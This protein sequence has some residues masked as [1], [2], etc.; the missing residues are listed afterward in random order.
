MGVA[1]ALIAND[2]VERLRERIAEGGLQPGDMMEY[3]DL[4]REWDVSMHVAF[5]ALRLLRDE[6]LTGKVRGAHGMMVTEE[7]AGI[8]QAWRPPPPPALEFRAKVVRIAVALADA[9]G[10]GAVSMRRIA[11]RLGTATM[12][13]YR[14]VRPRARLDMLMADAVFA[15]HRPPRRPRGDWRAQLEQVCRL[16]WEMYRRRPW[17]ARIVRFEPSDLGEFEQPGLGEHVHAHTEWAMRALAGRGE[18]F[19]ARAAATAADFV[20]G[21]AMDLDGDGEDDIALFEF[22]LRRLLDGL[23]A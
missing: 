6:G 21:T 14:Y 23:A 18:E 5:K 10:L 17:L 12:T 11:E 19:A 16:Q 1:V 2:I 9:E 22:G 15:K 13:P 4:M 7:A 20:R 3:R 8:A